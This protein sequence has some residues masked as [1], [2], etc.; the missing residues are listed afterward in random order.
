M[1]SLVDQGAL[2]LFPAVLMGGAVAFFFFAMPMMLIQQGVI[3]SG[4][5]S[6]IAAAAPPLGETARSLVAGAFALLSGGVTWLIITL[7]GPRHRV[8]RAHDEADLAATPSFDH[9]AHFPVRRPILAHSEFGTPLPDIA[10]APFSAWTED[11]E[12]DLLEFPDDDVLELQEPI[13]QAPPPEPSPPPAED[14]PIATLI[15][16]LEAGA[17]RRI[18]QKNGAAEVDANFDGVLRSALAELQRLAIR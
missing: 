17:A 7:A 16:R 3:A 13:A 6:L 2:A 15:A 14:I 8:E 12:L 5:P 1:K 4:L 11:A 10:E 9:S 18:A